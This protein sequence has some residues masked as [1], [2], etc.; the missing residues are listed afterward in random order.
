MW[1]SVGTLQQS[2]TMVILQDILNVV[3]R[4]GTIQSYTTMILPVVLHSSTA[5]NYTIVI[6]QRSSLVV[7]HGH[8]LHDP[9]QQYSTE[10]LHRGR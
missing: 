7:L 9:P 3:L 1:Y 6:L 10:L 2:N 4:G 5:Q 8:T